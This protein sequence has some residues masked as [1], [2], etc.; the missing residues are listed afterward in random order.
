MKKKNILIYSAVFAG[1]LCAPIIARGVPSNTPA[2]AAD[3]VQLGHIKLGGIMYDE[4]EGRWTLC[5]HGEGGSAEMMQV[6]L[7]AASSEFP[8]AN[9]KDVY[10][11]IAS[12]KGVYYCDEAADI[13]IDKDE[14]TNVQIKWNGTDYNH[15]TYL[16]LKAKRG[17][18]THLAIYQDC[19]HTE[20]NSDGKCLDCGRM[21]TQSN[22]YDP[23][24]IIGRSYS[25]EMYNYCYRVVENKLYYEGVG[26]IINNENP[27]VEGCTDVYFGRGITGIDA[28]FFD[29]ETVKNVYFGKDVA[30]IGYGA[31]E[32]AL[33]LEKIVIDN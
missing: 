8:Y 20:K 3:L 29:V 6:T 23:N 31:F 24:W 22:E 27:T 30:F 10:I 14:L 11:D 4:E 25:N 13:D 7:N 16:E 28:F 26:P 17:T 21:L 9:Q 2:H 12:P 33:A 1:F 18:T 15:V 5:I 19:L 32:D